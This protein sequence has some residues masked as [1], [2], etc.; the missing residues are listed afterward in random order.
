MC[1]NNATVTIKNTVFSS[2][3]A[4]N[5]GGLTCFGVC[6]VSNCS[7]TN[8]SID[9]GTYHTTNSKHIIVIVMVVII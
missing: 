5:G 7:F 3:K 9:T 1:V 4:T 8:N 6:D 2:N